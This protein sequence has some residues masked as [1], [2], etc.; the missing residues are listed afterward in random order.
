MKH[1]KWDQDDFLYCLE[2]EPEIIEYGEEYHYKVSRN[3]LLLD[4]RVIPYASTVILS[5]FQTGELRPVTAFTLLV[6]EE[7]SY[8]RDKR[9]EFLRFN[10]ARFV[11]DIYN[12]HVLHWLETDPHAYSFNIEIFI[13]PSIYIKIDV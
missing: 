6:G 10:R 12:D 1:L 4:L 8:V 9:G 5:L 11:E 3:G 2:V 7:V 13:K